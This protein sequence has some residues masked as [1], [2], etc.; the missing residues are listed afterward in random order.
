MTDTDFADA[1]AAAQDQPATAF[2]ALQSLAQARIGAKLFTLMTVTPEG[3]TRVWSNSPEAYPVSGTKP[4]PE[5]PWAEIVLERHE[6][7]VANDA[8]GL[9]EVFPDHEVIASLGC[10]S[11]VNVPCV[12]GGRVVGSVNCLD[13]AGHYTLDRVLTADTLRVPGAA[14]FQLAAALSRD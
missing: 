8:A 6:I 12:A 10:A 11:V 5:G 7:F 3:A 4:L 14:A 9:A 13:V 1:L 2:A